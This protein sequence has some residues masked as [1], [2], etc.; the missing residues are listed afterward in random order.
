MT[1]QPKDTLLLNEG[2]WRPAGQ[3]TF[4]R[5]RVVEVV[6]KDLVLEKRSL[7]P[8]GTGFLYWYVAVSG[9]TVA[10]DHEL[11][12]FEYEMPILMTQPFRPSDTIVPNQSSHG[13][14]EAFVAHYAKPDALIFQNKDLE[15][16]SAMFVVMVL[17]TIGV[18]IKIDAK[19]DSAWAKLRSKLDSIFQSKSVA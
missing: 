3:D 6:A 15:Y 8:D 2:A 17:I 18:V 7:D 14:P 11:R 16:H 10:L 12:T 13:K 1:S 9:D 5:H 4:I 19:W